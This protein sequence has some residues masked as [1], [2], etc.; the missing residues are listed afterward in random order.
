MTALSDKRRCIGGWLAACFHIV[1]AITGAGGSRS[2]TSHAAAL[3][4]PINLPQSPMFTGG[5]LMACFHII[6][7]II[8]AGVLGLPHALSLLGWLGGLIAL[9][10]FFAVTIWC[11]CAVCVVRRACSARLLVAGG[12]QQCGNPCG[13]TGSVSY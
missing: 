5:W 8:G 2:P 11:R 13:D 10:A 7:A 12:A 1:M 9:V 6:T 4:Q 3:Y